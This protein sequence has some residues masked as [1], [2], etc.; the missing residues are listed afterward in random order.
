MIAGGINP[1]PAVHAL[2]HCWKTNAM[3]SGVH[4]AIADMIVGHVDKKKPL[5]SLYV[6]ISDQD[7]PDAIDRMRFDGEESENCGPFISNR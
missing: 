3:R 1:R 5:Q 4:P 7:F 6:T 2:R